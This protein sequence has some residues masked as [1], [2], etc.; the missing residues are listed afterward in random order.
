MLELARELGI[1]AR[2]R[3]LG[4]FDLF[5]ADE[6]FLTGSGVGGLVPVRSLD[7]ERIGSGA[8][9]PL[10]QRLRAAFDGRKPR[11]GVGRPES[12]RRA[13]LSGTCPRGATCA[14]PRPSFPTL[15]DDPADAEAV[16][17][18]LLVRAGYVRQLMSGAYSLLPLGQ[19][20][21]LKI[22]AIVREEM[23]AIG[24]QEFKL[25][26]LHPA[27]LWQRS[28]R[29]SSMGDEMFRLKDRKRRRPRARHDPRG[30][31]RDARRASCAATS[32][33][34]RS[35]TRSRRSSATSR[36]RSR[37]CCACASSR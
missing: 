19:R 32:S 35:G 27:E 30:G 29:W 23:D 31:L 37:A 16:S 4:R 12:R 6:V 21:W 20:V 15:R 22:V 17:H 8:P 24:A 25:P 18:K 9:G 14:G 28:G 13:L 26:A 3:T 11:R 10:F 33:C 1:P 2:E 5:A 36:A 7:G 34:R